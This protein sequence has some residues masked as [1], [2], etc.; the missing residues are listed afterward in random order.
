M[1]KAKS[2]KPFE[3]TEIEQEELKVKSLYCINPFIEIVLLI[4]NWYQIH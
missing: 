1:L 2:Y 3:G 4:A